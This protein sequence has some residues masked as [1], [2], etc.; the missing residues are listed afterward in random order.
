MP[1]GR[2]LRPRTL[3]VSAVIPHSS[4]FVGLPRADHSRSMADLAMESAFP[5]KV[6]LVMLTSA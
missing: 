1:H 5:K 2:G 4:R 6:V 3:T